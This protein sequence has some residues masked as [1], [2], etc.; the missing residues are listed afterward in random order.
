MLSNAMCTMLILDRVSPRFPV[1]IAANRDELYRRP[2]LPPRRL[3]GI[4]AVAGIDAEGG[5]S[6]AGATASGFFVGLTNQRTGAPP[7]PSRL[8]RGQVVLECLR[9][10]H[11]AAVRDYL[12]GLDLA[13][14][15]PFNLIFGDAGGLECA[16]ARDRDLDFEPVPPGISVL[17]NDVLESPGFT[18]KVARAH[19][20]LGDPREVATLEWPAL[21]DRL[22]ATLADHQLPPPDAVMP[23]GS[24]L[25][26]QLAA[27]CIH[28]PLYGTRSVTTIALDP[29]RTAH[30]CFADGPACTTR[31]R[32]LSHLF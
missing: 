17:P 7:D 31:C 18:A 19:A 1:V 5:G 30:Y 20:L 11:R 23:A 22:L 12:T 14:Y 10:G 25:A 28:T 15:N 29:G 2:A 6:W 8:S 13:R 27:L 21:H 24:D 32:D 26:R 4:D 9:R 3:E 16:Y